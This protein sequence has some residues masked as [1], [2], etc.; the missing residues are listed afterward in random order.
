M[1][2]IAKK[3]HEAKKL[4]KKESRILKRLKEAHEIQQETISHIQ[5]VFNGNATSGSAS[6]SK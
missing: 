3:D 2:R 1:F 5:S 4:E 6:P